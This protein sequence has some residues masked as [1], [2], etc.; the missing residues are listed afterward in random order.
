MSPYTRERRRPVLRV[1]FTGRRSGSIFEM[2][3][4]VSLPFR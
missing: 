2:L 3:A 1:Y 4:R